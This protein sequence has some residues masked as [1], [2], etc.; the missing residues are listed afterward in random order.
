M[1]GFEPKQPGSSTQPFSY[2]PLPTLNRCKISS[3][4]EAQAPGKHMAKVLSKASGGRQQEGSQ[5]AGPIND[6]Q[7]GMPL[8]YFIV[9]AK[10]GSARGCDL[11]KVLSP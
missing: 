9:A 6:G 2:N 7:L 3:S 5:E 10:E 1:I 11:H 4:V 8:I